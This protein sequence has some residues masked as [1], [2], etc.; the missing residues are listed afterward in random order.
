MYFEPKKCLS[1]DHFHKVSLCISRDNVNSY[2]TLKDAL[3]KAY[4][5]PLHKR[6]TQVHNAPPLGDRSPTQLLYDLTNILGIIDPQDET[7][8]RF[9][10]TEF[11]N[12]LPSNIQFILAAFPFKSVEKPA[13]IADSLTLEGPSASIDAFKFLHADKSRFLKYYRF[14]LFDFYFFIGRYSQT[15][16]RELGAKIREKITIISRRTKRVN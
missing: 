11:M 8:N 3:I 5:L 6:F 10:Q 14:V 2:T 4:S 9:L 15:K 1:S 7:L 16:F 12:R 13:P